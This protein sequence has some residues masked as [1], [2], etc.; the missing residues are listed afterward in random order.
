MVRAGGYSGHFHTVFSSARSAASARAN[1]DAR[2][3]R[4]NQRVVHETDP[5]RSCSRLQLCLSDSAE[6]KMAASLRAHL[7]RGNAGYLSAPPVQS[8]LRGESRRLVCAESSRR[9]FCGDL[10]RLAHAWARLAHA[11]CWL[12]GV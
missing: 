7:T 9:R 3:R 10:C 11:L 6:E 5:A 2:G 8:Q 4:W 12:E 1:D